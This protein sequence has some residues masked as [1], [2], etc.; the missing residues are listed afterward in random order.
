LT[1]RKNDSVGDYLFVTT[2]GRPID[3]GRLLHILVAIGSRCGVMGVNVHRF[4]HTFAI[5]YLRNGGDAYT[6][7]MMLGHSTMEMVK[8]YLALAQ[9]DLDKS[10]QL[11]SPVDHWRL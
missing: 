8:R 11:A 2:E 4:R 9:A 5:N 1:T 10:H 6:L 7:Q 3:R